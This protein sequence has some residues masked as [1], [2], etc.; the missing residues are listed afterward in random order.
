[1]LA[2]ADLAWTPPAGWRDVGPELTQLS[3]PR[4]RLA[5]ATFDVR[6]TK[7]DHNCSPA[8]ARRQMPAGGALSQND[9]ILVLLVAILIIVAL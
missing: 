6:Q 5:A 3:E 9:W 1:M 2:V 8:T 4:Q 7:P